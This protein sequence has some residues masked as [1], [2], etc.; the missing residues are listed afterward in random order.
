MFA[1]SVIH[2]Y[3]VN[4]HF[5]LFLWGWFDITA[6]LSV[7]PDLTAF[8]VYWHKEPKSR[9]WSRLTTFSSPV[10]FIQGSKT[11]KSILPFKLNKLILKTLMQVLEKK[12]KKKRIFWW[13]ANIICLLPKENFFYELHLRFIV[14]NKNIIECS[15]SL[16]MQVSLPMQYNESAINGTCIIFNFYFPL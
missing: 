12:K 5:C 2:L 10:H 11:S 4:K 15:F 3:L 9:S 14:M 13:V 7:L 6:N 16:S 1:N 8:R